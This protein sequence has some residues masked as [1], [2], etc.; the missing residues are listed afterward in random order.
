MSKDLLY[1]TM[2]VE[3]VNCQFNLNV[4]KFSTSRR[5]FFFFFCGPNPAMKNQESPNAS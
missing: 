5:R 3:A 4:L 1:L 2:Y